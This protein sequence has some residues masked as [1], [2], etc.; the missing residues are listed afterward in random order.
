MPLPRIVR[1]G[2]AALF[3][4]G[5]RT[6]SLG[7]DS[8][9]LPASKVEGI[10]VIS[11]GNLK[12]GGTGK[13]PFVIYLANRLQSFGRR[14]AVI[15]RGYKGTCESSWG[16]VSKGEGPIL[17]VEEA[18]DEAR[19]LAEQLPQAA[20][21]I[22]ADRVRSV[23]Q[24]RDRGAT[25][26]I[27]DDGFSHRRLYRDLDILLAD[28]SDLD[29]SAAFFP[30]GDLRESPKSAARAHLVGGFE[31][32][33]K[34]RRT[35]FTFCHVPTCLVDVDQVCRPLSAFRYG[36]AHLVSGIARPHRFDKTA[37]EAGFRVWGRSMFNDHHRFSL[38]D[39]SRVFSH[40]AAEKADLVLTTEKDLV[41]M[42]KGP[43]P[44]P[45]FAL[46]IQTKIVSGQDRLDSAIQRLFD[47]AQQS[48]GLMGDN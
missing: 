18:G 15:S 30:V 45:L 48:S 14:V 12:V 47:G 1:R 23:T 6:K 3:E 26:A 39:L 25:V 27:L 2:A 24:A 28:P 10:I 36:R 4:L 32:A 8:G 37:E 13:T 38:R 11:V 41:R 19:L 5:V 16:I 20:V 33:W 31:D 29:A 9:L 40:A 21:Y 35:D 44:Q 22:G 43:Y 34:G 42:S 46:R 17:S 7:Y